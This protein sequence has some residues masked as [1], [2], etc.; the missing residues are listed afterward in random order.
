MEGQ[1]LIGF[2]IIGLL[3]GWIAGK[4]IQG[5]GFGLFGNLVVGVVGAFVGGFVF[6]SL[7]VASGGFVGSLVT[8]VIGAGILLFVVGLFHKSR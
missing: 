3:A 4:L 6:Q 7:G 1:G 5:G 2:L 8:A